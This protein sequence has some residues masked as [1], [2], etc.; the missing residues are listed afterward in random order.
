MMIRISIVSTSQSTPFQTNDRFN[1]SSESSPDPPYNL[2][3]QM[4]GP[5]SRSFNLS[6]H[7]T[8]FQRNSVVKSNPTSLKWVASIDIGTN[9]ILLLIAK[10]EE[11]KLES[12]FEMETVVRL[13]E[14][15]QKNG[16]LS[17]EAMER[18]LRALAHY[19]EHCRVMKT[20]EVFAVGTS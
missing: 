5:L 18:G 14:G 7:L 6:Q 15:V 2:T 1:S 12:L 11:G 20:Q 9:T 4:I 3:T 16:V 13:G 19:L 17:Q 8:P 10:V